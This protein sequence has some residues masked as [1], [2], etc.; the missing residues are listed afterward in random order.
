MSN[1][2]DKA[3]ALKI[4]YETYVEKCRIIEMNMFNCPQ[5]SLLQLKNSIKEL[6][7]QKEEALNAWHKQRKIAKDELKNESN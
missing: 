2:S 3:A 6:K 4:I 1:A 7:R 5:S